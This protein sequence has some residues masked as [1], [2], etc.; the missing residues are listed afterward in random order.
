MKQG[1]ISRKQE[2]APWTVKQGDWEVGGPRRDRSFRGL[3][4]SDLLPPVRHPPPRGHPPSYE[5]IGVLN[6]KYV[7]T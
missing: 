3:L 2:H 7:S 4:S 5:L 6:F 1:K